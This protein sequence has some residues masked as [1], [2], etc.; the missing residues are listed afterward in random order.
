MDYSM[1]AVGK[2]GY[3]PKLI[4]KGSLIYTQNIK[5]QKHL[6]KTWASFK[7]ECIYIK[8]S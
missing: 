8:I 4:P 6:K 5:L 3:L 2:A 7:I 1:V